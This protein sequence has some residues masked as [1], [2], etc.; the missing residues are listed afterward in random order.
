MAR[1]LPDAR[2]EAD[3]TAPT[4]PTPGRRS[5]VTIALLTGTFLASLDVTVV[6]T[7]MP[8]IVADLQGLPLYGWVFG[9][10]Q[11]L[12][13]TAM[14][15]YGKLADRW[16][17]KRVYLVG[18]SIFLIGSIMCAT[19]PSME[20]L[21]AARAVQG[22][23]AGSTLPMTMTI[24]GDLYRARER[25]RLQ[26]IFSLVWGMSSVLGPTVGGVIV[27]YASWPWIFY[28]N[29]P[30]GIV[31]MVMLVLWFREPSLRATEPLDVLGSALMISVL[32]GGLLGVTLLSQQT[33]G[34]GYG[35]L[36]ISALALVLL[37]RTQRNARSPI[38][39]RIAFRDVAARVSALAGPFL[40]G[41][42][43]AV[44]SF[45]PLLVRG[46]GGHSAV[47]TG[48]AL[49]PMSFS[50]AFGSLPGGRLFMRFGYRPVIRLGAALIP[51]G[52][53]GLMFAVDV[54]DLWYLG[55]CAGLTGLGMGLCVTAINIS[56]QDRVAHAE[57]GAVTA[58]LVFSRNVGGT[59]SVSLLGLLMAAGVHASVSHLNIELDIGLL[60]D[61]DR[62]HEVPADV[63]AVAQP[64][65]ANAIRSVFAIAAALG[66]TAF[67]T[68]LF[69]PRVAAP[70]PRD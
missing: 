67:V 35:L 39:P 50:W 70:Q 45:L 11:L 66:A 60:A 23:G 37:V 63:L 43:F 27:E 65:L 1:A 12:S 6:G 2:T 25:A 38:I 68:L 8:T 57:R 10:Y 44:V 48:A 28:L 52:T 61:P 21:V 18:M 14:P 34:M 49:I 59:L 9:A 55:V 31:T 4:D 15:V 24:F 47:E 17:R 20:W 7:A 36:V 53:L 26:G 3:S 19:A 22:L 64:G 29:I 46:V 69:F 62:W 41:T 13:T 58:M 54:T 16:G 56:V 5:L 33:R 30:V 42:L 32:G 51:I 40:G